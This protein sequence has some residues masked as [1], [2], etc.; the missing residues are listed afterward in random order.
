MD[1]YTRK[2]LKNKIKRLVFMRKLKEK[3]IVLFGAS[4]F[5][6]EVN[7]ILT[8]LDFS[9]SA[10]IDNDVRKIGKECMGKLI[11]KPE[12][13]LSPFDRN[14]AILILSGGFYREMAYQLSRMGYKKGKQF[15]VLNYKINES[16][17]VVLNMLIH[18]ITG[19]V[20][21]WWLT[22]KYPRKPA[23]FIAPYTGTGDIYLIG[24]FFE[25]FLR[26]NNIGDY[27]FVVVSGACKKVA[28]SS[29][30]KNVIA[31]KPHLSDSII[32]W[33]HFLRSDQPLFV[34]NDG[35]MGNPLQWIRGY[36]GLDFEKMFRY[37]VFGFGNEVPHERPRYKDY[38]KEIDSIFMRHG[39]KKGRTVVLSPHSNT[40][41]DLP[42]DVWKA[43]VD[44]C[45]QHGYTVC[46][47]C[48]GKSEKPIKGTEAVFFPLTQAIGFMNFAGY[49]IG[50][51]SGLCDIISSS[52]CKKIVLYER[53]G[54]FYKCSPF[55][56]FSLRKMGLCD[57]ILELEYHSDLK[58]EILERI[59]NA[60]GGVE[61]YGL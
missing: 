33:W 34:L 12:E 56:Y 47:N 18:T 36:R 23:V 3:R 13:V 58:K 60:F 28:E 40:L 4:V 44:Y 5:S 46:T 22:K 48:A 27:V 19:A 30:I 2:A 39:L 11:Q 1:N 45:R 61:T 37:F 49:F 6:K 43:I 14:N 35:W 10:V 15:H 8:E 42:E 54:F 32:G 24:L 57:D 53:D 29:G 16:L 25:E 9:I 41:F 17:P 59:L 50:V 38:S 55:D 20:I 7:K 51:R 31:V 52:S 26:R 21:Y